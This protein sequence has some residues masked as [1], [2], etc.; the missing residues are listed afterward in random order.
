MLSF[1]GCFNLFLIF[2]F[3][4]FVY[5]I[6]RLESMFFK[7][8][9][10]EVQ[11]V[12][13][14]SSLLAVLLEFG[15]EGCNFFSCSFYTIACPFFIRTSAPQLKLLLD[16]FNSVKCKHK[17]KQLCSCPSAT[18]KFMS[19]QMDSLQR[20]YSRSSMNFIR[21]YVCVSCSVV[22][23]SLQLHGLQL[24]KAP[25]SMEFSRQEYW[26]G[27]PFSFPGDHPNP[28][29]KPRS[30]SLQADFYHLSHQGSP[31]LG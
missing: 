5:D 23:N 30:P 31:L 28:G 21:V 17:P 16:A 6:S 8:Q 7:M 26:S 14:S 1:T 11:K 12:K 2:G 27:L 15:S 19:L 18:C 29:I 4:Q 13:H 24:T 10:S 3:Y 25:R 22:S 20:Q 9:I